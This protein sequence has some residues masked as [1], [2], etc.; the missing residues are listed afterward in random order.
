MVNNYLLQEKAAVEGFN[1]NNP[2]LQSLRAFLELV[3]QR[4][5]QLGQDQAQLKDEW[6]K[7][8]LKLEGEQA[9]EAALLSQKLV[10]RLTAEAD[11][12]LREREAEAQ[13]LRVKQQSLEQA[14]LKQEQLV[15]AD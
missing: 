15:D 3:R 1:K 6:E 7:R 14:R 5:A 13:R 10:Q 4:T 9:S 11:R 12:L 2:Q 8:R